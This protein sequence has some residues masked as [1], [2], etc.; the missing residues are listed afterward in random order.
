VA[1]AQ[2]IYQSRQT[3]GGFVPSAYP[4]PF[5]AARL[6]SCDLAILAGALIGCR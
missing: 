5:S 2:V 3:H 4:I 6:L 1:G